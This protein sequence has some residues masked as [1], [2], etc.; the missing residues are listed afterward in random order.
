MLLE[1]SLARSTVRCGFLLLERT[2]LG[3]PAP[4]DGTCWNEGALMMMGTS[5]AR[6][7]RTRCAVAWSSSVPTSA[8]PLGQRH[9]RCWL[10]KEDYPVEN[11]R[12]MWQSAAQEL[13]T[14]NAQKLWKVKRHPVLREGLN[15]HPASVGE[16]P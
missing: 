10:E 6:S 14:V 12:S 7:A 1:F 2:A 9:G 16:L 15:L 5:R 11:S 3:T 13:Q 4:H 8:S